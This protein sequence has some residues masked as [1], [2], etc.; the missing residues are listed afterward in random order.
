MDIQEAIDNCSITED[1]DMSILDKFV[2]WGE[3]NIV[4]FSKDF[5]Y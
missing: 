1:F 2:E 5:C 3:K 4:N